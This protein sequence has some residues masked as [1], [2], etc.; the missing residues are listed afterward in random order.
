MLNFFARPP[1]GTR[2][3][4]RMGA[5]ARIFENQKR[6]LGGD[7]A[8]SVGPRAGAG[9]LRAPGA[10]SRVT[11]RRR[12]H[13][14]QTGGSS[15]TPTPSRRGRQ[16]ISSG[17]TWWATWWPRRSAR[18]GAAPAAMTAAVSR[19]MA[20]DTPWS[21]RRSR[22]AV[23]NDPKATNVESAAIDREL[24]PDLVPSSAVA[25]RGRIWGLLREPLRARAKGPSPRRGAGLV[26]ELE[27]RGDVYEAIRLPGCDR[28]R[29]SSRSRPVGAARAGMLELDMFRDYAE[30]GA[31]GF[32]RRRWETFPQGAV[33]SR[34][35]TLR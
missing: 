1:I 5:K 32:G 12:R 20:S 17:R 25:S 35:S 9:A 22:C 13:G 10:C 27:R 28:A 4:S 16:S 11:R 15:T 7:H 18:R 31:G 19:S 26:R 34:Q 23:F 24:R 3:S 14:I 8:A 33:N 30:R 29:T 21:R 2:T 6:A